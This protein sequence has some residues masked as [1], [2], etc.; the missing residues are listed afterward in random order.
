MLIRS[1]ISL[2][3]PLSSLPTVISLLPLS[4]PLF[5]LNIIFPPYLCLLPGC[6]SSPFPLWLFCPSPHH[7][8]FSF[9]YSLTCSPPSPFLVFYSQITFFL[10][11]P[12]SLPFL[13]QSLITLSLP[14]SGTFPLFPPF[15]CPFPFLS[16]SLFHPQTLVSPLTCLPPSSTPRSPVPRI[17]CLPFPFSPFLVPVTFPFHVSLVPHLASCTL[18]TL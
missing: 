1:I 6:T 13:F 17:T 16:H 9:H 11:L 10:L 8:N 3:V 12:V 15:T 2:L 4:F 14:S 7:S 18:L 5:H